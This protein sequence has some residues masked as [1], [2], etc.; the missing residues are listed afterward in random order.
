M[1]NNHFEVTLIGRRLKNSISLKD[2]IVL[3][4]FHYFLTKDFSF[5]AE[6][7]LRLFTF[8]LFNKFDVYH[9]N[10]LDTL[11][12]MWLISSLRKKPIIYDSHEYFLGVPE[13]QNRFIVKKVWTSI[14]QFIFPKLQHVFTVNNS[15]ADLYFQDYNSRPNVIR[16]LPTVSLAPKESRN[17]LGLR[18]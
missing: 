18:K 1:I 2:L 6:Y 7:N 8:L 14:E 17:H 10:D 11:L 13:I 3:F 12:P 16:N 5:Y 9:S 15:I 4:D